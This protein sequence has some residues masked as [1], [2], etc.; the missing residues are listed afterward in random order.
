MSMKYSTL[1]LV[2]FML[3]FGGCSDFLEESSLDEV[4]PSSI[5]DLMQIMVGEVYPLSNTV[6]SFQDFLTD[7]IECFGAQ[8][9]EILETPI[10]NLYFLFSWDN[11]MFN[12]RAGSHE[13]VNAWKVYYNKIMGANTVL[14]YL[15]IVKGDQDAKDNLR[16]QALTMRAWYYF[17]LVNLYGLPY[18]YGDPAENMGVP[19]K[20]KMEI[21][22]GYYRRNSVA[23]VYKQVEEDLLEGIDL[24]EKNPITMSEYKIDALAAKSILSRVYLYMENWDE[25]LKYANEVLAVKSG[26][27]ALASA[28]AAAFVWQGSNAFGVYNMETSNE[29]IW[30]YSNV[31]ETSALYTG[32]SFNYRAPFGVSDDLMDLYEFEDDIAKK[33]FK[34]LRPFLYF[35]TSAMIQG[36]AVYYQLHGRKCG[37]KSTTIGNKGIR[38]AE[39]YLNR[40]EAY[41]R[42]FMASG[43][44]NYRRLALDDLNNLRRHRYDT[45]NVDYVPEDYQNANELLEFCKNERRRE[46]C[47]EDHRWFDLRR[48]GMPT[49]TH[50][51]FINPDNKEVITLREED[52]RYV[53]PIPRLA[54][55]RNPLL[56]QNER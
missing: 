51:Y 31:G 27:T 50:T 44:D 35:S 6:R 24:L 21:A 47:F 20:L 54:L 56:I 15:D 2:L 45:R 17:L 39:L 14:E 30:L 22:G 42:K 40:A 16:G 28:E 11:E 1:L 29:V 4:R 48:Y 3:G 26:L 55:D 5:D 32:G 49:L 41:T 19:L 46:L 53:L 8:G 12:E 38:T 34:D 52:P 36:G 9:Q 37:K 13:R 23:E 25:T 33:N 18:N 43:D 10:E 7:D